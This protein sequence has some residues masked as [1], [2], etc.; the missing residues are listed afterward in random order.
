MK[1][2]SEIVLDNMITRLIDSL[3]LDTMRMKEK[4]EEDGTYFYNSVHMK[5]KNPLELP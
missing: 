4:R 3:Y 2:T 5:S 1:A